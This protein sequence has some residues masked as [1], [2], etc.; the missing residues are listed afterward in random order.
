[1]SNILNDEKATPKLDILNIFETESFKAATP[2]FT[3]L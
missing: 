3:T 1:M 2:N